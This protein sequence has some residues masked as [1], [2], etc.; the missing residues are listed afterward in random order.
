M[1]LR[2]SEA[3]A[4]ELREALAY[5]ATES[6][7]LAASFRHEINGAIK[8]IIQFPKGWTPSGECRA[9]LLNRFPYKIIYSIEPDHILVVAVAHQHR[10]PDYWVE[11]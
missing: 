5:Y 10:K 8:R 7:Q 1:I 2:F 11:E 3:A 4:K 9:C 6:D